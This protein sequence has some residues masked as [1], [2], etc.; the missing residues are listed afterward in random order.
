[1]NA[2]G[3]FE[4]LLAASEVESSE[5]TR[6]GDGTLKLAQHGLKAP[7]TNSKEKQMPMIATEQTLE[8]LTITIN[9]EIHVQAF[10]W[11]QPLPGAARALKLGPLA[12]RRRTA[13]FST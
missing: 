11:T 10:L 9:Q 12:T 7:D 4:R 2:A 8:N 1:M 6:G 3:T 5:G 13:N